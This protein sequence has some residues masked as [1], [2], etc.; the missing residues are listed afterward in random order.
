LYEQHRESI[1]LVLL[2]VRMTPLDG[3]QTLAAL[4]ATGVNDLAMV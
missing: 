1:D 3:P 2:D 4:Q